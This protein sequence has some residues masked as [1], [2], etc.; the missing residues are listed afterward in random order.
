MCG[1]GGV[2]SFDGVPD[3]DLVRRMLGRLHHRGPDGSGY[4]RD[5]RIALGHSRLS[6][7]DTV[8]G[9]QPMADEAETVWISFNG[10]IFNY[11]E[12]RAELRQRGHRFRTASDTEVIVHAW[13]E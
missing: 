2:L 10:E 13:R 7:I 1:I 11:V 8:G 5:R 6:I 4:Y 9:A 3:V 12:L